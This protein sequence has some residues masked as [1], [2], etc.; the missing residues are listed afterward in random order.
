MNDY[1]LSIILIVL[2]VGYVVFR[3]TPKI[4]VPTYSP[5]GATIQ[6][7]T[8]ANGQ[9]VSPSELDELKRKCTPDEAK[10]EITALKERLDSLEKQM[11]GGFNGLADNWQK[12]QDH[13]K[14][15]RELIVRRLKTEVMASCPG[16]R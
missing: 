2:F 3:P 6:Q 5:P 7:G 1:K 4:S 9:C 13:R 12:A 14:D 16:A 10:A 11:V 15:E 8:Q